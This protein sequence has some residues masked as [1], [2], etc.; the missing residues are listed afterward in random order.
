MSKKEVVE[1]KEKILT[2][3]DRK[4]QRRA[5]E[6]KKAA[7]EKAAS[8][9]GGIVIVVALLCLVLSFPIRSYL[10][11]NGTFVN[12]AGEKVSK[13]E[14][15]Y[16]YNV[17]KNNYINQYS[18]YMSMLGIDLT[19][20]L[21]QQMYS[22]SLTWEDF[23][24]QMAVENIINNKA[25]LDQAEAEGFTY[26]ATDEYTEY[27]E[28]IKKSAQNTG[29]SEKQYIRQTYGSYATA[30]RIKP[31][32]EETLKAGAYYR[33][34]SD[35]KEPT[36]EAIKAYYEENKNDYD[37]IDYRLITISADL[38][39]EPTELA[40]PVEESEETKDTAEEKAYVPS[41]AEVAHAMELAKEE[42]D[43]ALEAITTDGELKENVKKGEMV[44]QI[45][46]WL[47]E[48]D[49][50]AGDTT[51]IENTTSN[52]YYVLAFEKR[53]LDETPSVDARVI[54]L[55]D[56]DGQVILDEWKNSGATEDSFAALADQYNDES[57]GL[58][59]GLYE[60][61]ISGGM[62]EEMEAWIYD[63]SRTQGDTTAISLEDGYTYVVY[64]IGTNMPEWSLE[65]SNTLIADIMTTYIEEITKGYEV[66]DP[67]GNL[68]Y[69]KV[70]EAE[71]AAAESA[72]ESIAS[73]SEE[74]QSEATSTD[75]E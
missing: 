55:K 25:L 23:F 34:V 38:P 35:A 14:F 13:V 75:G 16:N 54:M 24:Q 49:R 63:G 29:V 47:F 31:Y 4:V 2:K 51:V 71:K 46:D 50:K 74:T 69:L 8:T 15:D 21:S 48:A 28:N 44:S 62:P 3:Y 57:L 45:R 32:V 52:L 36:E 58:E 60:A 12:V 65:I 18:Y 6:K 19:G 37:S 27:C 56:Q 7:K 72:A 53:Y 30:S 11:V 22:G 33:A 5:E 59:G 10:T 61:L 64:Y 42:A 17:V 43:K 20:D 39:T 41:E 67:K 66:S 9:I 70:Q 73:E 40:D 68:K 26:D 1:E